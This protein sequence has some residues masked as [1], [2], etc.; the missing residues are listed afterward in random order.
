MFSHALLPLALKGPPDIAQGKTLG[1]G[2]H[3]S[4]ALKGRPKTFHSFV[5]TPLQ[6][7]SLSLPKTQ[8]F[9]LGYVRLPLWG[10]QEIG[11]I[12]P[13]AALPNY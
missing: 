4:S 11:R 10:S 13:T 2:C 5:S 7:L 3:F 8:G 6:G 9:T 12:N 1:M